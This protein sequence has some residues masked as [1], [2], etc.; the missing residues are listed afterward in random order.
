MSLRA[1]LTRRQTS[2][3]S[4][5]EDRGREEGDGHDSDG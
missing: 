1:A 3:G 4:T 5:P 2:I